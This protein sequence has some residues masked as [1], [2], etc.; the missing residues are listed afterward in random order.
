MRIAVSDATRGMQ[1]LSRTHGSVA[2]SESCVHVG[3]PGWLQKPTPPAQSFVV[4]QLW[5]FVEPGLYRHER[6]S[7][8]FVSVYATACFF[9]GADTFAGVGFAAVSTGD[10]VSGA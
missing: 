2:Q 6:A 5:R 7:L 4:W 10:S 8:R 9:A 3:P 1:R